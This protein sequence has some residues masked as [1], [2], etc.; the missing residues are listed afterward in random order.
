MDKQ[1][2]LAKIIVAGHFVN[3]FKYRKVLNRS[4]DHNYV[5]MKKPLRYQFSIK[6]T[7]VTVNLASRLM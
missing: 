5:E 7:S 1:S 6:I 4:R 2:F 3:Y